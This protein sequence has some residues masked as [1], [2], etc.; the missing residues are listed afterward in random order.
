[1]LKLLTR[2]VGIASS[3]GQASR[4]PSLAGITDGISG[5]GQN[6]GVG[7]EFLRQCAVNV[8]C[9]LQTPDGLPGQN[10]TPRRSAGRG[11]TKSMS[12]TNSLSCHPIKGGSLDHGITVRSSMGIG[13]IIG[14]AK[15]DIGPLI[16]G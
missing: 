15:Q 10:R 3:Y 11:I 7:D 12:E 9:F 16:P 14:Y 8:S 6:L 5:L 4:G 2:W 1:M 13:L